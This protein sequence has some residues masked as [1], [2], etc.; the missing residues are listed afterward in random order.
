MSGRDLK[1]TV[2]LVFFVVSGKVYVFNKTTG[3]RMWLQDMRDGI[4]GPQSYYGNRNTQ[5]R[6]GDSH[7]RV[8]DLPPPRASIETVHGPNNR[9]S[10]LQ[11]PGTPEGHS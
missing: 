7:H 9:A 6:F 4:N 3:E 2:Q 1:Y 10:R 5:S 8:Q 11:L